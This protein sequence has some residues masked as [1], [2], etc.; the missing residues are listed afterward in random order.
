VLVHFQQFGYAVGFGHAG[1]K[2]VGL[3]AL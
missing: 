3:H 2:A 1:V